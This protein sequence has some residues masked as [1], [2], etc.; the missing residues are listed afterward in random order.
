VNK[1]YCTTAAR[2][3]SGGGNAN[4]SKPSLI[5]G[6]NQFGG[7]KSLEDAL[8]D[9][10]MYEKLNPKPRLPIGQ[11]VTS[12]E[13][14]EYKKKLTSWQNGYWNAY[15]KASAPKSLSPP[16]SNYAEQGVTHNAV[17]NPQSG[18]FECTVRNCPGHTGGSKHDG[19][20]VSAQ[21]ET[22][23][24]AYAPIDG[25]ITQVGMN[26][27]WGYTVEITS[28]DGTWTTR[29]AH[30]KKPDKENDEIE[31][32]EGFSINANDPIGLV[33]NTGTVF[34]S[35]ATVLH[36]ELRIDGK[37]QSPQDYLPS[38]LEKDED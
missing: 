20:D 19:V 17:Y 23:V 14:A 24:V 26:S 12:A 33:G 35:T 27:G 7:K 10:E 11:T 36:L 9:A 25:I 31:L 32:R 6:G 37:L 28:L 30:L 15:D 18:R 3:Q 1:Q 22:D 13:Y 34:P 5:A 8:R 4:S 2:V 21:G 16:T 38:I 29:S